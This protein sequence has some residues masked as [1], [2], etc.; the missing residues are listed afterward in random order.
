MGFDDGVFYRH[1]DSCLLDLGKLERMCLFCFYSDDAS[2]KVL[3]DL[4]K[5]GRM[6]RDS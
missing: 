5:L 6:H 4:G 2:L 3:L 1:I